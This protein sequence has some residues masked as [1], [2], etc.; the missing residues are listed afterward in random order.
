[1]VPLGVAM[2]MTVRVGE[3][4]G[5]GQ[6]QR[7]KRV[8]ISGW[9][10]A[11][12][13]MAVS[14]TAFLTIGSWLAAQFV[15]DPGVIQIAAGLLIIAG[16]FQLADG[17]QV[18]CSFALRGINDVSVPARTAFIAYWIIALPLGAYLTFQHH[19]GVEG[20]WW[21]LTAGL[22]VA[23]VILGQRAWRLLVTQQ[24]GNAAYVTSTDSASAV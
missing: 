1:M 2:A 6:P 15:A 22:G 16:V 20:L 3:I 21:G 17:F 13:F 7:L 14:M 19:W 9:I 18:I 12:S 4:V 8:L 5:A 10:F 11:L 24:Q 23:A